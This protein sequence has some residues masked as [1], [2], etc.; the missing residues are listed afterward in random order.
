MIDVFIRCMP[1]RTTAQQKRAT[2]TKHGKLRFFKPAAMVRHEETWGSLLSRHTPD[3]PLDG[4][5]AIRIRMVYPHL[6]STPKRDRHLLIPKT[7]KPDAGNAAKAI[8]DMLTTMRFIT[9]DALVADLR[10]QKLH[11]PDDAVGIGIRIIPFD[12]SQMGE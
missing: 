2:V 9:D 5:L 12:L 8:E 3:A 7:T 4:P 1:P 10:I 11:G 6:R